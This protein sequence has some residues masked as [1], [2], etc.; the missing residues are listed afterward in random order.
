MDWQSIIASDK[1]LLLA[2]NGSE[3]AWMD[4]F[5]Y[6][7][8]Q[9]LMWLPFFVALLFLVAR[10]NHMRQLM[11][12]LLIVGLAI[13][14]AEGV[15][16][17]ICKGYFA[18]LRPTHD[19]EIMDMVQVVNGYRGGLYSFF[20]SHASNTF[21]LF[22]L[23]TLLVRSWTVGLSLFAWAC[24]H[25]Y[26]RLYLGVHFPGDIFTGFCFGLLTGL[27]AY[28]LWR[29]VNKRLGQVGY[30]MPSRYTSTGYYRVHAHIVGL[31][32]LL[33]VFGVLLISFFKY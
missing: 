28:L 2:L 30:A 5:M 25:T 11:T 21:C 14:V 4:Q 6:L 26:T 32:F 16:S 19:P 17:G 33:N 24:L 9:T 12:I 22:M 8:T 23:L 3:W 10:N 31:V 1:E 7:S 27:L 18:R 15:S 13:F 20:S 29:Y